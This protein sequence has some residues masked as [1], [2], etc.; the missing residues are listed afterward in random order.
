MSSPDTSNKPGPSISRQMAKGAGWMVGLRVA[1]RLIGVIS[2][3]LLAR[4]LLPE[5][6]G[7]VALSGSVVGLLEL[8]SE[9]S[10]ETALIRESRND[11]ALYDSAWTM[12]IVRAAIICIALTAVAPLAAGFFADPRME[13][14][15]Y[16]LALGVV[17]LSCENI[18]V[19]EFRKGLA[20][21][22]E[23]VYLLLTRSLAALATISVAFLWRNYWALVCGIL[24]Q[25]T[26]QVAV[27]YIVH[28]FRPRITF[29]HFWEL[30]HF[31]KW[32][33]VQNFVYGVNQ[34][35]PGWILGRVSGVKSV[36]FF[37][38]AFEIANLAT[39]EIRAPIRRALFPG[40][41][42]LAGDRDALRASFLDV[43]GLM[44]LIGV[45]IPVMLYFTAPFIVNVFLGDQWQ[46]SV[47]VI[48]VLAMY[49]AV[50]AFGTSGHIVYLA[51]NRPDITVRMEGVRFLLYLPLL[52]AGVSVWG[53]VGAAWT[54]TVAT[55]VVGILDC[56]YCLELLQIHLR[57][58]FPLVVRPL[59]GAV[60]MLGGLAL[61]RT[62]FH[63]PASVS[64]LIMQGAI[65]AGTGTVL[66]VGSVMAMWAL[67]G[68][69]GG[70]E[71]H[72]AV[73]LSE[74][75]ERVVSKRASSISRP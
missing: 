35:M 59:A 20:F 27:S 63:T 36:A 54:L 66:Y 71:R 31:S 11:R 46:A 52:I 6:F 75:W 67:T 41:A 45:P 70:A 15:I 12:K 69:E 60:S 56:R 50:Q 29:A 38:M 5:H 51:L 18:G 72:L 62:L 21:E 8:L 65:L 73:A 2:L 22:K 68:R 9:F 47:P 57:Q 33:A 3:S 4:L 16:A 30:F 44:V 17:V 43:Y 24:L 23:F 19:V 7:L 13:N 14:V 10:L 48:E 1:D 39:S 53:A 34:R 25:R 37:D 40:F 58:L 74:A 42:K 64:D 55:L 26:I 49:G 32:M 61:L 28:P